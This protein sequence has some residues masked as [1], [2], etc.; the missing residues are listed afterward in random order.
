MA[1]YAAGE[2]KPVHFTAAAVRENAGRV[3]RPGE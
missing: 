2:F 1:L 3:Y